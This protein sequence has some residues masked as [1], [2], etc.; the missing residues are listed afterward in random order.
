M[1]FTGQ[2]DHSISLEEAAGMTKKFRDN[3]EG[4]RLGGFFGKDALQAILDQEECVGIRFYNAE[5]AE[6]KHTIVLVG[7]KADQD[8]LVDGE[9]A[10]HSL[11]H[12]P[13]NAPG[14]ALN[15]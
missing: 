11:P 1:S 12:P 8:D 13:Y 9:L 6:G 3:N 7:A 10:E 4:K 2:E 15:S 5:D 14:N